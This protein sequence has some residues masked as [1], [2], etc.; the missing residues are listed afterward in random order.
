MRATRKAA[1]GEGEGD[2]ETGGV[3]PPGVKLLG[4]W[5][6]LAGGRGFTLTE[7]DDAVAAAKSAYV[8]NDLM[9]F[10]MVP[11]MTDDRLAKV[12]AG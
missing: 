11:A 12:L 6:D 9:S 3:P 8:W 4:R 5:T 10:E 1:D 2:M 7:S